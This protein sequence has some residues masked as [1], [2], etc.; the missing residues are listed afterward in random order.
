M[1]VSYEALTLRDGYDLD[2]LTKQGVYMVTDPTNGPDTGDWY[3]H[4][5]VAK[6][7]GKARQMQIAWSDAD[8]SGQT[9]N[10][11][12]TTGWTTWTN[13]G[14]AGGGSGTN[15]TLAITGDI[16]PTALAANTDDYA[17]AGLAGASVVRIS[18]GSSDYNVTGLTTGSDGRV[19][20]AYNIGTGTITFTAE[21]ASSAA[22]N[23][24]GFGGDVVVGPG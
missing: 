7:G 19:V 23:R 6:I 22:A 15:D 2:V 4:V 17:P 11:T 20:I 14:G 16:T 21:D 8:G 24:F 1:T 3:V 5:F 9:R 18:S 13:I 12:G 10:F